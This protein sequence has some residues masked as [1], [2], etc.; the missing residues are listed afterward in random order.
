MSFFIP[1]SFTEN[2]V[3]SGV[4]EIRSP[5][6]TVTGKEQEWMDRPGQGYQGREKG[7]AGE[8]SDITPST[9]TVRRETW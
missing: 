4:L 6:T 7:A 2:D 1:G 3:N 9:V 5:G 8:K